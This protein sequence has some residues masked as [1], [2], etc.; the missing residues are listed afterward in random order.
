MV[1]KFQIILVRHGET[2]CNKMRI[3]QGHLDVPLNDMGK[4]QALAAGELLCNTKFTFVYSSDLRRA[5]E[6]CQLLLSKNLASA[7]D[8]KRPSIILDVRL[9]ERTFGCMEGKPVSE[10]VN[11]AKQAQKS[12]LHYVAEGGETLNEFKNRAKNFFISLCK[13][14]AEKLSNAK[15]END[16]ITVLLVTHGGFIKALFSVWIEDNGCNDG[17]NNNSSYNVIVGNASHSCVTVNLVDDKLTVDDNVK[18]LIQLSSVTCTSFNVTPVK[19][20]GV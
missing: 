2:N 10:M 5:N 17:D 12:M 3:I 20:H 1:K 9:R 15:Y 6:T 11:A 19:F 13:E 18:D 7:E 8:A 14:I 4:V 16:D